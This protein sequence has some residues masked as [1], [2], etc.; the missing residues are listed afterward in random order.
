MI[1]HIHKKLKQFRNHNDNINTYNC[2]AFNKLNCGWASFISV[3]QTDIFWLYYIIL[4]EAY[5][6]NQISKTNSRYNF[7]KHVLKINDEITFSENTNDLNFEK[8]IFTEPIL[9]NFKIFLMK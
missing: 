7:A 2:S 6:R 4:Y 9:E 3:W 8:N 1:K 5:C